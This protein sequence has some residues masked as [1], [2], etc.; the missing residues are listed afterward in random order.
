M[1]NAAEN[2]G[3]KFYEYGI[4]GDCSSIVADIQR[5]TKSF[6]NQEPVV[7]ETEVV[8]APFV[9]LFACVACMMVFTKIAK[10]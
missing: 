9:I 6:I 7:K 10:Y 4:S 5:E 1:K 8:E 3:G 2:T